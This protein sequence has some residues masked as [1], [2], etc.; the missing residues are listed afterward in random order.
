[1]LIKR[2]LAGNVKRKKAP[3]VSASKIAYLCKCSQWQAWLDLMP[4]NPGTL[5]VVGFCVAPTYGYKIWL[6]PG[7]QGFNPKILVL[8]RI[9]KPPTGPVIMVPNGDSLKR[10]R[11]ALHPYGDQARRQGHSG[12][13]VR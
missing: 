5:H 12:K 2:T 6:K 8:D 4:P 1:M 7:Q 10:E 11:T 3:P 9:V 13:T